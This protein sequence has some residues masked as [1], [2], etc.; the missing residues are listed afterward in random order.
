MN[1][2]LFSTGT[3]VYVGNASSYVP[4]GA[5]AVSSG[6]LVQPVINNMNTLLM[7]NNT[8]FVMPRSS[9]PSPLFGG[10]LGGLVGGSRQLKNLNSDEM[11][12][13]SLLMALPRL[14][15]L[16][17]LVSQAE[18]EPQPSP[19]PP[20][21]FMAAAARSAKVTWP[22]IFEPQHLSCSPSEPTVAALTS[23]GLGAITRVSSEN[24]NAANAF[25]L[26]G[27]G[28]QRLAGS[29][30]NQEGL[31]VITRSGLI[32]ECPGHGPSDGTWECVE[33]KLKSLPVADG[34]ELL[35]AAAM[36]QMAAL[37]LDDFPD[38]VAVFRRTDSQGWR[39]AGEVRMPPGTDSRLGLAFQ[40]PELL[41]STSTGEVLRRHLTDGTSVW[42]AAPVALAYASPREFQSSCDLFAVGGL[43]R[44]ALRRTGSGLGSA[45]GPELI[46]GA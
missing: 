33:S 19:S 11:A 18:S 6:L 27:L 26:V 16:A 22:R 32:L 40:G 46:I 17:E 38:T 35:A 28:E 39:P 12:I 3:A 21:A 29:S 7:T 42:H 15:W 31:Q 36:G 45:W 10:L 23:R 5:S 13:E 4:S 20:S 44:L 30:W 37:Q 14:G 41:I 43:L 1:Y 2:N 34:S 9:T 24:A 25:M 8:S